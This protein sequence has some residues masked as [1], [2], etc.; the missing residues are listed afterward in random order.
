M[1]MAG[2]RAVSGMMIEAFPPAAK[3]NS[4]VK[5]PRAKE[6]PSAVTS[7]HVPGVTSLGNGSYAS[8]HK[9]TTA[10]A[11]RNHK[12]DSEPEISFVAIFCNNPVTPQS[13]IE[14]S[15]K[16]THGEKYPCSSDALNR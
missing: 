11:I 16:S 10:K 14:T 15:A 13:V 9:P 3:A 8:M 2:Y 4:I 1:L 12:A 6:K 7:I 5:L